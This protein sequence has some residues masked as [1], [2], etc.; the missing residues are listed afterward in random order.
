MKTAV[1]AVP[2]LEPHRPPP[3]PAIVANICADQGHTVT[4]YDLNIKLFNDFVSHGY[5]F[6]SLDEFFNGYASITLLQRQLIDD[7][8]DRWAQIMI[9]F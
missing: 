7:F 5:D 3:G 6:Y 4:V 2:R 8:T 9:M 1:I